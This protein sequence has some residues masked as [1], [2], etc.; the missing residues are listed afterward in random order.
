[1]FLLCAFVFGDS[2][3]CV[4]SKLTNTN[5]YF[6][7]G[8][9][10]S[11]ISTEVK[12]VMSDLPSG[13][14]FID[15]VD[16]IQLPSV[17]CYNE[18]LADV[19]TNC[20]AAN[21]TEQRTFALRFTKCFYNVS[22]LVNAFEANQTPEEEISKMSSQT[23]QIF[24]MFKHHWRNICHFA[25]QLIFAEEIGRSVI[26]LLHSMIAS[27]IAIHE[28]RA[29]LQRTTI[30]LNAS[31][32]SVRAQI[33]A[34]SSSVDFLVDSFSGFAIPLKI[35]SEFLQLAVF[36]IDSLKYYF[37]LLVI[38]AIFGILIPRM[39]GP[40]IFATI[41]AFLLD[42]FLLYYC[43]SWGPSLARP[44]AQLVFTLLCISYPLYLLI[45]FFGR[46][47]PALRNPLFQVVRR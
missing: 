35:A 30:Q 41:L 20:R 2:K 12:T 17:S 21:D 37:A 7:S 47:L 40:V 1:M 24:T 36:L 5:K 32:S 22:G 3:S 8:S 25:Q 4:A 44:V 6:R 27:T 14:A 38:L 23:Y 28:L 11:N 33:E 45:R 10:V 13:R 46:L 39:I 42:R 16:S 15:L 29:D 43:A 9:Q 26:D 34:T 18:I 31:I 19:Q